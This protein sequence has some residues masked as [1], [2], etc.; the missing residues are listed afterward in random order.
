VKE[1]LVTGV[2]VIANVGVSLDEFWRGVIEGKGAFSIPVL[3]PNL[4]MPVGAVENST[5]LEDLPLPSLAPADRSASFAIAATLRALADAG[6][7][8]PLDNPDRVAVVLGTGGGGQETIEAQYGRLFEGKKPHPLTVARAMMSGSASLV[9][10]AFGLKGPCFVTSSACASSAHAIGIAA[11]LVRSGVVNAAIAGGTEACLTRGTLM[12]WDAMRIVSR[13]QCRP[14]AK[15]RDGL[16]I[17]EGAGVLILESKDRLR[18]RGI[19]ADIELAGFGS[20][21]DAADLFHPSAEGMRRAMNAALSE[22]GLEIDDVDYVNAHGTGTRTNDETEVR[23]M[24]LVFGRDRLPPASSTK[25]VTG[26]A[27]G[28]AGAIEAVATVLAMRNQLA[29]PTANFDGPDPACDF[30][31]IPNGARAMKIHAA[32]SNSFGFG[33]LNASIA[34][35][36][37][38]NSVV[39]Q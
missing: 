17:S 3:A 20:S 29:P 38:G 10:M 27:L 4:L 5:H 2:G 21:A 24:K 26:H 22:A 36:R 9:S 1:V 39:H 33:G 30:D 28:A 11:S 35:R 16:T 14:F 6:L 13:T 32:L 19:K 7:S 23:A 8:P 15:G 34:F 37:V 12:A 31:C 18:S 25:G